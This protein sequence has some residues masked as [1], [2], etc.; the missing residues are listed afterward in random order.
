MGLWGGGCEIG[1]GVAGKQGVREGGGKVMIHLIRIG[2][3][4]VDFV[5]YR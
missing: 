1:K 3:M 4:I 2:G 5:V